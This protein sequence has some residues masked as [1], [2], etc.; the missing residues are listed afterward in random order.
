MN[1]EYKVKVIVSN[2]EEEDSF[3]FWVEAKSIEEAVDNIMDEL[4]M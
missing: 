1:K 4:D 3:E 2:A